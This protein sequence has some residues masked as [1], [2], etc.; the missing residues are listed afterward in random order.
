MGVA[1]LAGAE[2]ALPPESSALGVDAGPRLPSLS[3]SCASPNPSHGL[4]NV[5]YSL[6][7]PGRVRLSL[8]DVSG[9]E[10]RSRW[11]RS[12]PQGITN[13]LGAAGVRFGLGSTCYASS[14][15]GTA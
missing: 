3:L 12:N 6:A 10:W 7:R 14:R 15:R 8:F 2:P 5:R 9:V 1:S 11:M 4:L 13:D